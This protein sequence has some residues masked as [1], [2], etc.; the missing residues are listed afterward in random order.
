MKQPHACAR[1]KLLPLMLAAILTAC[2]TRPLPS[3][4]QIPG[5]PAALMTDDLSESQDYSQR[6]RAWLKKAAGELI[7]LRQRKPGCN[8]TRPNSGACS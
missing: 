2:A 3:Q 8:K 6:V 7:D 5:P 4:P 1:L